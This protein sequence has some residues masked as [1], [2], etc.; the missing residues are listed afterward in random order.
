[1]VVND[2]LTAKMIHGGMHAWKTFNCWC[3]RQGTAVLGTIGLPILTKEG[4]SLQ[5]YIQ[6]RTHHMV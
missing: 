4:G 6:I 2:S 3:D 5:F 1:M